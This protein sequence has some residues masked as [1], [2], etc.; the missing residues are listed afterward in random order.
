MTK[1]DCIPPV[2][3][4]KS[5]KIIELDLAP[6]NSNYQQAKLVWYL[7]HDFPLFAEFVIFFFFLLSL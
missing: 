1:E 2:A 5:K 3:R 4:E 6:L 7:T